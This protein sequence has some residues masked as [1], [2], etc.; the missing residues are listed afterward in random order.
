MFTLTAFLIGFAGSFHCV[1]MC[2]PIALTLPVRH[3]E[4]GR[5]MAGILLYNA[6]RI[7]TYALLGGLF[8]WMGKQVVMAG[9]QQRL[10]VTMGL[11]LLAA[12]LLNF[13]AGSN[14]VRVTM[15]GVITGKIKAELGRLLAAQRF[16]TLYAIGI[17]N[18]LL[19]CGLVYMGIAGA[20][21]TGTVEKGMLFMTAFGA[22]TLP[23][24]TAAAWFGH[25]LS[26]PVRNK[27]RKAVPY[28]IAVMGILLIMRGMNLGIPYISPILSSTPDRTY[29]HCHKP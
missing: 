17:L 14:K 23:A 21:S 22:G 7:S 18:G 13:I 12:V 6:G 5:K 16:R 9:F 3:L 26:I 1:G 2:G 27:I 15:P 29:I 25:L 28:M 19:P 4:G 10:S 20:T 8:G 24:M 11:L